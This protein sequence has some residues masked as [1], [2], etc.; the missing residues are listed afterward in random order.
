MIPS[1]D[2]RRFTAV[3]NDVK[4]YVRHRQAECPGISKRFDRTAASDPI[5]RAIAVR[6]LQLEWPGG[7]R[8][9]PSPDRIAQVLN[10][11]CY[12]PLDIAALVREGV[13]Y[14]PATS[15]IVPAQ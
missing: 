13:R 2:P 7:L 15:R 9:E 12:R 4:R 8:F 10:D 3:D 11:I 5:L 14:H 1:F 6:T